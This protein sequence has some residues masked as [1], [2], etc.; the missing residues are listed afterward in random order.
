MR[1]RQAER[2]AAE[3]ARDPL[4]SV[5]LD[6][7][8][9]FQATPSC[10][11]FQATPP[12][13]TYAGREAKRRHA[14]L[15]PMRWCEFSGLMGEGVPAPALIWPDLPAR[16][17]VVFDCREPLFDFAE[18]VSGEGAVPAF[19]FLAFDELGEPADLVAW[20]PRVKRLAA[21]FGIERASR[22]GKSVGTAADRRGRTR[23]L[24][25]C[26]SDGCALT[27]RVRSSSTRAGPG[28]CCGSPSRWSRSSS[29]TAR[30][31]DVC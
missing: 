15:P 24:R 31:C 1:V 22:R 26:R 19:V 12:S 4:E 6:R 2:A 11:K 9:D 10:D 25:G 16:G 28:R 13:R 23:G 27:A 8:N 5:H 7:L 20:S 21:W 14:L 17:S 3:A 29:S 18:E 30:S